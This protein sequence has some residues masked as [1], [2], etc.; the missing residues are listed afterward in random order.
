VEGG[1]K[2]FAC[3]CWSFGQCYNDSFVCLLGARTKRQWWSKCQQ[4]QIMAKKLDCL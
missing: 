1:L 2:I 3:V 4:Q